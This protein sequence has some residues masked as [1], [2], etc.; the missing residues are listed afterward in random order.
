MHDCG[1]GHSLVG[2]VNGIQNRLTELSALESVRRTRFHVPPRGALVMFAFRRGGK[3]WVYA[4]LPLTLS[5][6][7]RGSPTARPRMVLPLPS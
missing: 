3:A 1:L 5:G 7:L 2:A 6:T 4:D